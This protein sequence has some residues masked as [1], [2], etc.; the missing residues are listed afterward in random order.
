MKPIK[1]TLEGRPAGRTTDA[2]GQQP[3]G[4]LVLNSRDERALAWLIEEVG[5]EA[6]Q[7]ACSRLAGR[8]RLY[9]TNLAKVL[10]LRI[11][12]SVANIPATEVLSR[13]RDLRERF[14]DLVR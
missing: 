5:L 12:E 10:G 7:V 1:G 8:R 2:G 14:P 4:V 9:A 13:I 11:P 3:E 6:V